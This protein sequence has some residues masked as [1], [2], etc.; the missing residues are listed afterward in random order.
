MAPVILLIG[1]CMFV[2][3]LLVVLIPVALVL[4]PPT[5]LVLGIVWLILWPF[6]VAA[7]DDPSKGVVHARRTVGHWF[8]TVLTPWTYFDVPQVPPPH[9]ASHPP[10]TDSHN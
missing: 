7:H 6:A 5:L 3:P 2:A 1:P 10:P 4:W 9:A 8:R